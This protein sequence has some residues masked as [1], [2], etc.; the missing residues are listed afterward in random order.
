[1][2]GMEIIIDKYRQITLMSATGVIDNHSIGGL[3]ASLLTLD[4]MLEDFYDPVYM[5]A[6]AAIRADADLI[7]RIV[8]TGTYLREMYALS[9]R[10]IGALSS[11]M[12]RKNILE[13]SSVQQAED[14]V[15]EGDTT[16]SDDGD[17]EMDGEIVEGGTVDESTD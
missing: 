15:K 2:D 3:V 14:W 11:L 13:E 1:M 17:A 7:Y 10:W 12:S 5:K 8:D 9:L 4:R 16:Y 6:R